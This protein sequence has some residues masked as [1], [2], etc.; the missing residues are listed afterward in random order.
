MGASSID[1]SPQLLDR[2]DCSALLGD[3]IARMGSSRT[4]VIARGTGST[5]LLFEGSEPDQKNGTPENVSQLQAANAWTRPQFHWPRFLEN[6]LTVGL[7][8]QGQNGKVRKLS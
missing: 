2:T 1:V 7:R 4:S 5:V 6:Q 8:L 3:F